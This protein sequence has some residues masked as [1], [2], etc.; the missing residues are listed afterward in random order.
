MTLSLNAE[1]EKEKEAREK[2]QEQ[3]AEVLEGEDLDAIH[4]AIE[5][6]V[7]K[8]V[9]E[10]VLVKARTTKAKLERKA[11]PGRPSLSRGIID[12][13]LLEMIIQSIEPEL[14]IDLDGF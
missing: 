8:G 1:M 2:A 14:S 11:R 3:L 12:E 13:R 4:D 5:E 9:A 6:A 7:A 10:E